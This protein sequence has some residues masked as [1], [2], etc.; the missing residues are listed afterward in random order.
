MK[1]FG[2]ISDKAYSFAISYSYA[3]C[4]ELEYHRGSRKYLT[5]SEYKVL[6]EYYQGLNPA[7]VKCYSYSE[8][9]LLKEVIGMILKN[10]QHLHILDAGCG[11]GS[12]AIF[13][14]LLGAIVVGVDVNEERLNIANKRVQFY[15]DKYNR[16][17]NVKFYCKNILNF[18]E[19][20]KFDLVW[21]YQSISHITPIKDFLEITWK[22]L[23]KSGYLMI[24]DSNAINPYVA[25]HAW[26]IHRR[27]GVY[28]L[29]KDPDAFILI[30]YARERMLYPRYLSHLLRSIG[31]NVDEIE[32]HG[33]FP[34]C[35]NVKKF[36][37]FTDNVFANIPF[38]RAVGSTY[39]IVAHKS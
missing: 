7:T 12:H 10:P 26:L 29:I 13:F 11:L 35:L 23:K 18:C 32:Y 1:L 9:R 33:F 39:I 34:S 20:E 28:T 5:S 8:A 17:L 38:L 19:N 16:T 31:Y 6:Q 25:F 2:E 22:N 3:L 15:Q 37:R 21:S 30:P 36:F 4:E 14:S 27:G 24:C